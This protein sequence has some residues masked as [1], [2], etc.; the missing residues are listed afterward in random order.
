MTEIEAAEV[1]LRFVLYEDLWA[2]GK[3]FDA[4]F[5]PFSAQVGAL[6]STIFVSTIMGMLYIYTGD[7]GVP[8]ALA[9]L[10]GG[11]G[12]L[13]TR[14]PASLQQ[15]LIIVLVLGIGLALYQAWSVRGAGP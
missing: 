6:F 3:L 14:L 4:V 8:T 2:D 1:L 10:V 11:A 5:R 7:L 15:G 9:I 12:L 13:T